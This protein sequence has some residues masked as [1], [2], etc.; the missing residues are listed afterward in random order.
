M[1]MV[2]DPKFRT[3]GVQ[4]WLVEGQVYYGWVIVC[5]CFLV[6]V[7]TWGTI[8]SFG[9]FFGYI[10]DE[11]GLSHAN[12]SLVFSLQ[13]FVTFGGAAVLGFVIDRYG[14]R[15]LLAVAAVLVVLGFIG[16]SQFTSFTGV[17]LAYGLVAAAG[18][19][20]GSVIEKTTPSQWFDRRRGIATGI[21]GTGAGVGVF[22]LPPITEG[23]IG[24]IGWRNAYVGLMF[25]FLAIYLFAAI[26]L[27]D[28]PSDLDLEPEREFP[29]GMAGDVSIDDWRS[30]VGDVGTIAKRPAFGL[31]FLATLGLTAGVFTILV[32]IVEFTTSVGL[33]RDIGV[34]ALS[35]TGVMNIIGKV[36][37]GVVADRLGRPTTAAS[38]GLFIGGGIGLLLAIP[39]PIIV[40]VAAV[41]FGF[42][43]GIQIGL[44]APVVADLFGTISLNSLFGLIVGSA[45]ISGVF[46][47]YFAGFVFDQFGTY[48]PA[49]TVVGLLSVIG[50]GLILVANRLESEPPSEDGMS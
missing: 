37:G 28:Q 20:I 17:L 16:V 24:V 42:G 18:F 8:W 12:T 6:G 50:G 14:V 27:T 26:L 19:A 4:N 35:L 7:I 2:F 33:G 21:A 44:L 43:W 1:A 3:I 38:S 40:L 46:G 10:V 32:S 36:I 39:D 11:F 45:A 15:R 23:L 5:A 30:Q 29:S 9:V 48:R 31:V 47:P 22:I 49:F 25:G 41:V 13:S 34:F